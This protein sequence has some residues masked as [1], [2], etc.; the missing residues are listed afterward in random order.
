[1]AEGSHLKRE[2][3]VLRGLKLSTFKCFDSVHEQDHNRVMNKKDFPKAI[4]ESIIVHLLKKNYSYRQIQQVFKDIRGYGS[5][6][7][8][9]ISKFAGGSVPRKKEPLAKRKAR[10]MV[11]KA[12][13]DGVLKRLPCE[14]CGIEKSEA[15]HSDYSKPLEVI[16]LCHGHHRRQHGK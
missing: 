8:G 6:S 13:K 5:P 12:I 7:L 16:W 15:H 2:P 10:A 11:T 4:I 9:F 1:M 14:I 3:F